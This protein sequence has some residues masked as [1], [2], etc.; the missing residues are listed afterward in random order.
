MTHRLETLYSNVHG[1][2]TPMLAA[3]D[4]LQKLKAVCK[5]K[6][7]WLHVEG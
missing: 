4:P 5:A 2:G 3:V 7:I 6:N 1:L